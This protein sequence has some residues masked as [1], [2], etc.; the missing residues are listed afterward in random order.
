MSLDSW[1]D[2]LSKVYLHRFD[3]MKRK[4]TKTAKMAPNPSTSILNNSISFKWISFNYTSIDSSLTA[5]SKVFWLQL[6]TTK[7][8]A[9]NW[10]QSLKMALIVAWIHGRTL[11]PIFT[12]PKLR[13][14]PVAIDRPPHFWKKKFDKMMTLFLVRPLRWTMRPSTKVRAVAQWR[15]GP[16][17]VRGTN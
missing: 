16:Q 14:C 13:N 5:L 8:S 7:Q 17:F 11:R 10:P 6:D 1:W 4:I 2:L 9:V 3:Q 15:R 12:D